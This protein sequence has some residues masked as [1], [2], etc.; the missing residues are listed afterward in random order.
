VTSGRAL[1]DAVGRDGHPRG[2]APGRA[3]L[4]TG[5]AGGIG[6]AVAERF[7]AA[8]DRVAI[9]HRPGSVD[10]A[11]AVLAALPGSGH[12]LVPAD[13][14]EPRSAPL[15]VDAAATALGGLDVLVN[16]A[17]VA[18]PHPPRTTPFEDWA[19]AFEETF[20]VNLLAPAHLVFAAVAHLARSAAGRVVNVS[21]RGAFRGEPDMAAYGASKAAL[22]AFGQ[23]MAVALAPLGIAVATV[24]PGFVDTPMAR[25]EDAERAAT[26]RAQSP[27]DRV[28]TPAEVAGAVFWLASAEAEWASGAVLDLNGASYLRT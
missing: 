15:V 27:F 13:L 8:G 9:T 10:R 6:R 23:S 25:L 24:A 19:A 20:A 17:A 21:S 11:A 3:V 28:A 4:V 7:A 16:N 2:A 1:G 12:A 18:P 26:I 22:N 5:G 14:T